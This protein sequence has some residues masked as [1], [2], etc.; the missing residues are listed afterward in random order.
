MQMQCFRTKDGQDMLHSML[1]DHIDIKDITIHDYA[2][3]RGKKMVRTLRNHIVHMMW[4]AYQLPTGMYKSHLKHKKEIEKQGKLWIT[5][6]APLNETSY[7]IVQA[8][9]LS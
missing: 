3:H 7:A 2:T 9:H 8:R 1:A 4:S 5:V 6:H